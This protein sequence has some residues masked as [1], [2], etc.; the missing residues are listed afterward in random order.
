MTAKVDNPEMESYIAC[1]IGGLL[2]EASRS[3]EASVVCE[4]FKTLQ[5]QQRI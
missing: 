3:R 1:G 5:G 4:C 2:G